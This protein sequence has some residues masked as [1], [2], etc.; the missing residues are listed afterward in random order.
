[1][2]KNRYLLDLIAL[3]VRFSAVIGCFQSISCYYLGK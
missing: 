3:N 2:S 1:M